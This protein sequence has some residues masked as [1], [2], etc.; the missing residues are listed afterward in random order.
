MLASTTVYSPAIRVVWGL[1]SVERAF[2]IAVGGFA[3]REGKVR[4][5]R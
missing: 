1:S 4:E 3:Q 2:D 5:L